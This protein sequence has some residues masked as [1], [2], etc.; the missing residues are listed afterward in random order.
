MDPVSDPFAVHARQVC[1]IILTRE[2]LHVAI[3]RH[4]IILLA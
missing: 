3:S 2:G 4:A 1:R